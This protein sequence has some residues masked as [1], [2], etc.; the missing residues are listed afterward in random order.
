METQTILTTVTA[1]RVF[2]AQGLGF[3]RLTFSP[4]GRT[5]AVASGDGR[6]ALLDAATLQPSKQLGKLHDS[7]ITHI[8]YALNGTILVTGGGFGTG[9]KLIDVASGT[10]LWAIPNLRSAFPVGALAVSPNGKLLA[11]GSTNQSI[12]VWD[13]ATRQVIASSPQ[14]VRFLHDITF[15]PDGRV[16]AFADE[17]GAIFL[18]DLSRQR[19]VRTLLGHDGPANALTFSPDGRTLASGSMDHTI[20]LW[21]PEIDQEVAVLTGHQELI[22]CLAFADHGNALLSGSRDGTLRLWRALSFQ[23]ISSR[24]SL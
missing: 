16:L 11:T 17:R 13:I 4:D 8:A 23:Q 5:L 3:G 6:V 2:N 19:P 24:R 18:W 21:H 9:I 14:K 20:R 7:Q 22:W 10:N 15:A 1:T 12:L